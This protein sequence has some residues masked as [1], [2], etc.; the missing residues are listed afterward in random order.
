MLILKRK[1]KDME[2]PGYKDSIETIPK[3]EAQG[4][5]KKLVYVVITFNA[6]IL[7]L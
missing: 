6:Y 5:H 2:R 4:E 3:D 1:K 7:I